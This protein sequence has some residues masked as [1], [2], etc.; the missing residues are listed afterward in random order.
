MLGP[1]PSDST[2]SGITESKIERSF[3]RAIPLIKKV[4]S[5][6]L[7]CSVDNII[8]LPGGASIILFEQGINRF[9]DS[10]SYDFND[11][12]SLA[13]SL[14]INLPQEAAR[15]PRIDVLS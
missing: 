8:L 13:E 15:R 3:A 14:S 5:K 4:V 1:T 2:L 6:H 7:E 10:G 9:H 12:V 11:T